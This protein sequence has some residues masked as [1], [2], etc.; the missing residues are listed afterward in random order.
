MSI[1]YQEFDILKK[2]GKTRHIVAP[3]PEHKKTLRK[4]LKTLNNEFTSKAKIYDVAD[5]FHGFVPGRS[6]ITA[7]EKHI[8]YNTTTMMD[9]S[10]FFDSITRDMVET[11]Y[12]SFKANALDLFMHDDGY[13]PQGFPTSPII[14]NTV[15]IP[16]VKEINAR[17]RIL[18]S[19]ECA[20]TI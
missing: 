4:W 5:K 16:V 1:N 19:G 7:A 2:N 15:M 12:P 17:I 3:T 13:T 8:K 18:F 9:I 14:A 20:L 11:I 10:K 6:V